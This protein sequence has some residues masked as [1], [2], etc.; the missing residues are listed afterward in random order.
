MKILVTGGAGYIGSVLV[1]KL[2]KEN[3]EVTVLDNLFFDQF[4]LFEAFKN[5]K[6]NFIKGDVRDRKFLYD[7]AE[8]FDLIIPLAALVGAPLCDKHP[9]M[10]KDTNQFAIENLCSDLSKSKKII[11]PVTNSG[12]G[13]K[14]SEIKCTEETPLNPISIYGKTKVAAEYAVLNRGNAISL[15]LATVFGVSSR[16][17][18]DLLVN[19]FVYEATKKKYL[20]IF[21]GHFKRNFVHIED[22]SNV[23]IFVI[24]NFDKFKNNCYNFGLED[25]NLSKLELAKYIQKFIKDL[26][27]E[28]SNSGKDPDQ[29]NYIVSNQKI[30]NTGFKFEFSLEKGVVELIKAY[31]MLPQDNFCNV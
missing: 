14:N 19:H 7:L 20:K 5:K 21:E 2:L 1:P 22:V 23:I 4:T 31:E 3:Y 28:E 29:R 27:I 10:A 12:Y 15:R 16:M 24:K 9:Q 13:T 18:T 26:I 8:K 6:F 25:A 30:L 11:L 17:R